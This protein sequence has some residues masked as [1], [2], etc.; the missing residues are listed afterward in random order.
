[1]RVSQSQFEIGGGYIRHRPTGAMFRFY[2]HEPIFETVYWT[3]PECEPQVKGFLKQDVW[4]AAQKIL[5]DHA[6]RPEI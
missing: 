4:R 3:T 1:M 6:C 2:A 5:Q